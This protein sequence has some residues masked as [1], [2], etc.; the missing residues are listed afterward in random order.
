MYDST[1]C[2]GREMFLSCRALRT[3]FEAR[4]GSRGIIG[5]L[6]L[7]GHVRY[8]IALHLKI[9]VLI[10]RICTYSIYI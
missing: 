9:T 4:A 10:S 5:L 7:V 3:S 1:T 8:G 2:Y 6:P